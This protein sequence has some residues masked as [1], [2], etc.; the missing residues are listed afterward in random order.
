MTS[1]SRSQGPG[2]KTALLLL[3]GEW[4]SPS[5]PTPATHILELPIGSAGALDL[6]ASVEIEWLCLELARALGADA[7]QASIQSFD[8][9]KAL[10]VERFDRQW[11]SDGS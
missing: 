11:S 6:S 9:V 3:D 4:H 10:V 2:R 8:G 1:G 5:R 7:A